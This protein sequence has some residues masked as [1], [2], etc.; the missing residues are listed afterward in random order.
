MQVT[1]VVVG[2]GRSEGR[3][4]GQEGKWLKV[5]YEIEATLDEGEDPV[6][7]RLGIEHMLDRWLQGE[8]VGP[9]DQ[10]KLNP[11]DLDAL[12]WLTYKKEPAES[13]HSGW[14]KNPLKFDNFDDPAAE[15]LAKALT[16]AGGKLEFGEYVYQLSGKEKQFLNRK[17]LKKPGQTEE[18]ED[19]NSHEKEQSMDSSIQEDAAER[20]GLKKW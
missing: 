3:T 14:I 5:F 15:D 17:P 8:V 13:G 10:P 11:A 1:K 20:T 4:Q 2:K 16:Q 19:Q 9:E 18:E 7:A 6:A 12:P